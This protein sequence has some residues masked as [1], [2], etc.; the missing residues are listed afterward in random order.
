MKKSLFA[1]AIGTFVLG[2][3]EFVIEGILP[4]M[5]SD[6][7]VTIPQ[8]GH[9]ISVYAFGVC[10]GATLLVVLHKVRP[11]KILLA[12]TAMIVIGAL[13]SVTAHSYGWL[14]AARFISGLPHGAFFGTGT[15]VAVRMADERHKAT[16][17]SMMCVGMPVANVIGVPLSTYLS[18]EFSW[19]LPFAV[20]VIVGMLCLWAIW[21]WIP[22]LSVTSNAGFKSQ[23]H[24]L[25][26]GAPWLIIMATMLGN[27]GILAYYSY[28]SPTLTQLGGLSP[29]LLPCLMA[30]AGIG[31]V[32]GNQ[33]SGRLSDHFTPGRI[34]AWLQLL[35]AAGLL[36]V[37]FA[38][39]FLFVNIA[40]MVLC[41]AC[42]FGVG[43]P[44]QYLIVRHAPNGEMLGGCCIQIAFNFGNAVGAYL[45]GLPINA[46]CGYNYPALVGLP[47]VIAGFL[48]LTALV[49]RYETAH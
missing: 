10:A 47:M 13:L 7:H 30:V 32:L 46:D 9:A 19:R 44:E 14:L 29:S 18:A 27:G 40:M 22:N 8:A 12:L 33:V 34:A 2:M 31:M 49:R 3:A 24:F 37:F 39:H 21:R 23:F 1:L 25:K 35:A 5:A 15:I 48:F 20:I 42:L 4:H 38:G 11:K 16:A 17:V 28:I 41:C 45:G 6:L 43:T 36:C 26:H